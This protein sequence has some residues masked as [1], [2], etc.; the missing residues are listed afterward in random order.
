MS[1]E[2][3]CI[4]Y[5]WSLF[6]SVGWLVELVAFYRALKARRSGRMIILNQLLPNEYADLLQKDLVELTNIPSPIL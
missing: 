4:Q 1:E 6:N 2:L 3:R 5:V